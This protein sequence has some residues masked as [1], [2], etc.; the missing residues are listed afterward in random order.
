MEVMRVKPLDDS[1]WESILLESLKNV[2][3]Y[4]DLARD[5][6]WK[7]FWKMLRQ[8]PAA[9]RQR[10]VAQNVG[11]IRV[12]RGDGKW[13]LADAVLRLG[14]LVNFEDAATNHCILVDMVT[15]REDQTLV[16]GLDVCDV[17]EGNV[18]PGKYDKVVNDQEQQEQLCEWLN[19]CRTTYKSTHDNSASRSYLEPVGLTMPKG[20]AFLGKLNGEPNARLTD[21]FISRIAQGEFVARLK[22][23]H[24]TPS[25]PKIDVSHP[26]PW[27]VLKHGTVLVSGEI[28]RLAALVARRHEPA[29]GSIPNWEQLSPALDKLE[30]LYPPKSVTSA[31]IEALWLMLIKM[32]ATPSALASD[33]LRELWSAAAKDRVVPI[34][35]KTNLGEIQLSEVFVTS[36][37][38]LARRARTTDRVV[39]TLDET[40]IALWLERGARNLANLIKPEWESVTGPPDIL[41][42]AV[43]DLVDVMQPEACQSARCQQVTG[44]RLTIGQTSDSV[45]CMMWEN[46]LLLDAEQLAALTRAERMKRLV[47]EVAAAGWLNCTPVEALQRLGDALVERLRAE[48]ASEPTLAGRLLRAVGNRPE[49]LLDALGGLKGMDFIRKCMPLQLAELV[50]SHLGPATLSTLSDALV[51]EGLKPPARWNTSDAR[52][53]VASIGF[54]EE[55]AAAPSTRREPEEYISGPIKLP[56]LHDF[57]KEVLDGIR[58]LLSGGTNRRRAV[59]SLPTGGGKTRVT[60]EAAIRL[61]LA[62]EGGRRSVIWVAQTDELCEQAVQAFRQVWLNIGAQ[63]TD[64]RIV[65]MW[66]GNP[67][68]AIQELDR[69]IA[70]VA[71]IQTLNSRMGTE[72]L[73]WLQKP[74]LVVVDECHHAI[75]PSYTNLLRWLDAEAQRPG[76]PVRDEPPFI[77]LSATPFRTDDDESQRLAKRFDSRWLP[78]DQEGLHARLLSQRVLAQA[79]YD[80]L[81][82]GVGLSEDEIQLLARLP[83]PWEGLDFENLLEAIN[84]RLA[85]DVQRNQ[86]LVER[87]QQ[88]EERSILFFT[89]SVLLAE[90]MSARLNLVGI[91]AGA[92]SGSTQTVARRYF[93]DRFQRGEIRVLCN[94]SVLTTG[95][96][97]PQT[98][99]VFIAR[100][101]FSP[102]RYMQMVGRGLRGEKNGGTALCRIVTVVDNLGRFQDRHPYQYCQRYFQ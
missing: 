2:P 30:K 66:G 92:V 47:D 15:H 29:L 25:Y 69:P 3:G 16:I 48:V 68:P 91:P 23:G 75:T 35:F 101:V 55:F 17:P 1:V 80:E 85:G 57:Q 39:V 42:S 26:L 86:K 62:P 93:L 65:R 9:I 82:S 77:G 31:D 10:F 43:P 45:P 54:P 53:F 28:V 84:Q 27:L 76:A 90:E 58:R 21:R 5:T 97:A 7:D 12:R 88:C 72:K 51:E 50:L 74:G 59:V 98:D 6:G 33:E 18:G 78:G 87:I 49:P 11:R 94:H 79:K 22:F 19:S 64:L 14:G 37:A 38:D 13:V 34:S 4:P 102:V 56:E 73:V 71:S 52:V 63:R 61:V 40:A 32:L 36:S 8:A 83:D 81:K 89:N 95:F 44:L 99:M 96:D 20:W 60:V 46:A 41:I 100:Q 70:I 67:S 24:S